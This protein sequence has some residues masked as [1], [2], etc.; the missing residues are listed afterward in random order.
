MTF[1]LFRMYATIVS[2][3]VGS[4]CGWTLLIWT[5]SKGISYGWALWFPAIALL[6]GAYGY[7]GYRWARQLRGPAPKG[8]SW[9][10]PEEFEGV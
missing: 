5:S 10:T 7:A 4:V 8:L 3:C 2:A 6:I 9:I 1:A